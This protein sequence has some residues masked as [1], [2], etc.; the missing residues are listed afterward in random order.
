MGYSNNITNTPFNIS[1]NFY[2]DGCG[3]NYQ[4]KY[5]VNGSYIDLCG[6]PIKEYM[7]NPY[8]CGNNEGDTP[9]YEKLT[10]I[11]TIITSEDN[12][13]KLYQAEAKYA[14]SSLLK[15]VILFADGFQT[16]LEIT[17]GEVKSRKER[18]SVDSEIISI[19]TN[20]DSDSDFIYVL[21]SMITDEYYNIYYGS[22][23]LSQI[24]T[25][26]FDTC[27][28]IQTNGNE[29]I[30]LEYV[31]PESSINYSDIDDIQKLNELWDS[32]QYCFLLLL[33]E[34]VFKQGNYSINNYEHDITTN[35]SLFKNIN[36]G[37]DRYVLL[38][39]KSTKEN[40]SS[41]VPLIGE[42]LNYNYKLILK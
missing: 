12:G 29:T 26:D 40:L 22:Y 30:S 21:D 37:S 42:S 35:F 6:L 25:I 3:N 5:Y 27:K 7:K 36:I 11:I 9:E 1:D 39:E 16:E 10:N 23:P 19:S 13:Y 34:E 2:T 14:V 20:I 4:K 18:G 24:D 28:N 38:I 31:I 33:P 17:N 32:I 15:V 41:F 8:C